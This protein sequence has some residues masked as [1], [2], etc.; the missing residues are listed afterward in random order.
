MAWFMEEENVYT[1]MCIHTALMIH[2]CGKS[3]SECF[4]A[5]R[6]ESLSEMGKEVKYILKCFR[7]FLVKKKNMKKHLLFK[8]CFHSN[9]S[10]GP[11]QWQPSFWLTVWNIHT[12]HHSVI[13][14]NTRCISLDLDWYLVPPLSLPAIFFFMCFHCISVRAARLKSGHLFTRVN[15]DLEA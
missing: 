10:S 8:R 2:F 15:L 1:H 6:L 5:E 14:S 12:L 7:V 4:R 11:V 9:R 3:W 13:I